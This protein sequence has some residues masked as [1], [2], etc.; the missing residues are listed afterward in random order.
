MKYIAVILILLTLLTGCRDNEK[1]LPVTPTDSIPVTGG[2]PPEPPRCD[3]CGVATNYDYFVSRLVDQKL[4]IAYLDTSMVSEPGILAF[5]PED[6]DNYLVDSAFFMVYVKRLDL[7]RGVLV[8]SAEIF[9]AWGVGHVTLRLMIDEDKN[10]DL[11]LSGKINSL[12]SQEVFFDTHLLKDGM[13]IGLTTYRGECRLWI[14]GDVNMLIDF[15]N[16][17]SKTNSYPG[18]PVYLLH[19]YFEGEVVNVNKSEIGLVIVGLSGTPS[20]YMKIEELYEKYIR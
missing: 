10:G 14:G 2:D 13:L 7:S 9:D 19:E 4:N 18:Y 5:N 12:G 20:Q 16:N 17:T 8:S 3:T 1:P 6:S 11:F 15:E